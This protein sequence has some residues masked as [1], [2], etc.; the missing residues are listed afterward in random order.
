MTAKE[1]ETM[2]EI[3]KEMRKSCKHKM[4]FRPYPKTIKIYEKLL[5]ETIENQNK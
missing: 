3:L 2:K 4:F 1:I 5:K